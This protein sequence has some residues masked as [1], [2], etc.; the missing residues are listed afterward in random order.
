MRIAINREVDELL[1]IVQ[2]KLE[3]CHASKIN[4]MRGDK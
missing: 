3:C 1:D 4:A 2:V